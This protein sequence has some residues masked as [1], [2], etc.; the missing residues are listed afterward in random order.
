MNK[1]LIIFAII[2]GLFSCIK[3]ASAETVN[4]W[5][6]QE[7]VA[8]ISNTSG[9]TFA[10]VKEYDT[11]NIGFNAPDISCTKG[12]TT[13]AIIGFDNGLGT[14]VSLTC[15][16]KG[17]MKAEANVFILEAIITRS[18]MK[19]V[20]FTA[21]NT[22]EAHAFSLAGSSAAL[23]SVLEYS[24]SLIRKEPVNYHGI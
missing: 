19:I 11:A 10:V 15:T 6:S 16:S 24:K 1:S 14:H 21:N 23:T 13:P 3:A 7:N 9:S 4:S 17:I 12:V 22:V 8:M 18:V 20:F 5:R 2:G